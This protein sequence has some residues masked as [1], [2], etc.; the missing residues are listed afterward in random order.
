[1]RNNLKILL[2]FSLSKKPSGSVWV[3][4]TLLKGWAWNLLLSFGCS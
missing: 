3:V 1:M 4:K 2:S